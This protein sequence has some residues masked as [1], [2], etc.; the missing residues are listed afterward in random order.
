MVV[1]GGGV[2]GV[3]AVEQLAALHR[4][5]MHITLVSASPTVKGVANYV[6]LSDALESFDLTEL[7]LA[8]LARGR[9][10]AVTVMLGTAAR[11][12]V[13]AGAKGGV[14]H[15][16]DGRS[17]AFDRL[18]V[19]TGAVPRLILRDHPRVLGLRDSQV[20]RRLCLLVGRSH[21]C[22]PPA[23]CALAAHSQTVEAFARELGHCRRLVVVGNGGIA[24]GV[25]HQVRERASERVWHSG[26]STSPHQQQRRQP[27]HLLAGWLLPP[28]DRSR[29]ALAPPQR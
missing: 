25:V 4:T 7:D 26:D 3:A 1:L 19:A 9:E 28:P 16:S 21:V 8:T 2:A 5:D 24:L 17:V 11:V 18:C 27:R 29:C 14:V 6:K 13:A 22:G 10:D 15:L 20:G 23:P 12:E